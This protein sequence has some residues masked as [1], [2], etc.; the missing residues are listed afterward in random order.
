MTPYLA[1]WK[2]SL[3]EGL[4][5]LG[6]AVTQPIGLTYDLRSLRDALGATDASG[7]AEQLTPRQRLKVAPERV[8]EAVELVRGCIEHLHALEAVEGAWASRARLVVGRVEDRLGA[9]YR[10]ARA[11]RLRGLYVI[12][13]PEVA[14]RPV[15]EVAEAALD[16]GACAL[17][18]RDKTNDKGD[19][20]STCLR[21]VELCRSHDALLIMNDHAD[22]AA[23]CGAHGL[24][25]GQH[26]LA[27]ADARPVL[28][29]RPVVGRSNAT[30]LE[31]EESRDAGADYIAV[32]A[33]FPSPSKDNTRP[34]GLETLRRVC[35]S[36]ETPVVAIS[37][38]TESNVAD[39]I[40]AGADAVAVISA[41]VA[42]DDPRGAA[43]RLVERIEEAR[44]SRGRA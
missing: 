33:I 17:Q 2:E 9:E 15:L 20:L 44:A 35:E 28:G 22:L 36:A 37:G 18:W 39:V 26:D 27:I 31:A 10:R 14:R 38:I 32:G 7:A 8:L 4:L 24:H 29:P 16:G 23:A 41:V 21:L 42:A 5:L 30:L 13:D 12:V 19:Q 6:G 1:A 25:L 34:A 43:A 40:A 3:N 11:S